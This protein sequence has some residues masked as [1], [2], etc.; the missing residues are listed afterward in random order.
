ML[1]E[2]ITISVINDGNGARSR[3]S[4]AALVFSGECHG[5]RTATVS[6]EGSRVEVI[7][8]GHLAAVVGSCYGIY[9]C[10]NLS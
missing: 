1:Y 10:G 7:S 3:S 9:P 6:S 4:V 5:Y 8:N 2:V